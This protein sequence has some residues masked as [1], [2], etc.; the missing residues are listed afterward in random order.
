MA[1]NH[2]LM[3]LHTGGVSLSPLLPLGDQLTVVSKYGV[4]AAESRK[5]CQ[6]PAPEADQPS[7]I[8]T[9]LLLPR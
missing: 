8:A 1:M 6:C 9:C 5:P 7:M 4:K 2:E 3:V